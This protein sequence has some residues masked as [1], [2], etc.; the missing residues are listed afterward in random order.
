MTCIIHYLDST[1]FSALAIF[2]Y[3]TGSVDTII[4]L[5]YAGSIVWLIQIARTRQTKPLSIKPSNELI[6]NRCVKKIK[7]YVTFTLV[8]SL[9]QVILLVIMSIYKEESLKLYNQNVIL[10]S[11]AVYT[12][13]FFIFVYA[14]LCY[15]IFNLEQDIKN[16]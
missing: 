5:I 6:F 2:G 15:K 16:I 7:R 10:A 11:Y 14:F 8:L 4:K 3:L 12:F 13:V 1:H 9:I